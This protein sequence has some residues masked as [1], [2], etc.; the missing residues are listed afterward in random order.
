MILLK[1]YLIACAVIF[2]GLLLVGVYED[3]I[4]GTP[5]QKFGYCFQWPLHT[6]FFF[7]ILVLASCPIVNVIAVLLLLYNRWTQPPPPVGSPAWHD[8]QKK[9]NV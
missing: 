6:N 1:L 3:F 7:W 2:V 8:L 4:D 5:D 9:G